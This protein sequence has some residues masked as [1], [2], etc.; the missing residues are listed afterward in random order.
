MSI[1]NVNAFQNGINNSSYLTSYTDA[2]LK[3]SL[4]NLGQ[5]IGAKGDSVSFDSFTIKELFPNFVGNFNEDKLLVQFRYSPEENAVTGRLVLLEDDGN[6]KTLSKDEASTK[7]VIKNI[8]GLLDG[9]SEELDEDN[10]KISDVQ[11]IHNVSYWHKE[12][13]IL[14]KTSNSFIYKVLGHHVG[15]AYGDYDNEYVC[16]EVGDDGKFIEG[17]RIFIANEMNFLADPSDTPPFNTLT[18]DENHHEILVLVHLRRK[19][20]NEKYQ[21]E[22]NDVDW[23]LDVYKFN[24]NTNSF[25]D[26]GDVAD[27]LTSNNIDL[28][29]KN[30]DS[31][32]V[33]KPGEFVSSLLNGVIEDDISGI[34]SYLYTLPVQYDSTE[35]VAWSVPASYFPKW[36]S[37]GDNKSFSGSGTGVMRPDVSK[38]AEKLGI[39]ADIDILT[40]QSR[41]TTNGKLEYFDDDATTLYPR[42]LEIYNDIMYKSSTNLKIKE[43]IVGQLTYNAWLQAMSVEGITDT[44]K[45]NDYVMYMPIDYTFKYTCNS[46]DKSVIYNMASSVPVMF[47]NIATVT[48]QNVTASVDSVKLLE[49]IAWDAEKESTLESYSPEQTIFANSTVQNTVMYDL[50]ISYNDDLILLSMKWFVSFVMPYIDST[51]FW[52][53]NGIKTTNYAKGIIGEQGNLIITISDKINKFD[54]SKNIL[55]G[56][57]IDELKSLSSDSFE[58][59]EFKTDYVS[60]SSSTSMRD[61][62]TMY[63]YLPSDEIVTQ[64]ANTDTFSYLKGAV[65]MSMSAMPLEK[66]AFELTYAEWKSGI[67]GKYGYVIDTYDVVKKAYD[68]DE[69]DKR[70]YDD[71]KLYYDDISYSYIYRTSVKSN[72]LNNELGSEGVVMSFWT[73]NKHESDN[74]TYYGFDYIRKPGSQSNVAL[75]FSYMTNLEQYVKH[76]AKVVFSPDDYEH[77]QLIFDPVNLILKNN[78]ID[79]KQKIWPTILNRDANYYTPIGDTSKDLGQSQDVSSQQYMNSANLVIEFNDTITKKNGTV[80]NVGNSKTDRRFKIDTYQYTSYEPYTYTGATKN[81]KGEYEI[82]QVTGKRPKNI[83]YGTI[84]ALINYTYY[85][86]EYI[87]NSKY[88]PNDNTAKYQY[89]SLDIKEVLVR[90]INAENRVN[91]IGFQPLEKEDLT[92]GGILYNAYIGT[93]YDDVDKSILHIGTSS[94]N[95]NLGTTTMI[96]DDSASKLTK[97]RGMSIDFDEIKLNGYTSV[98]GEIITDRPL[99]TARK[100]NSKYTTYV[101]TFYPN[102]KVYNFDEKSLRGNLL[103]T[104]TLQ[105]KQRWKSRYFDNPKDLKVS[106][107]NVTRLLEEANI[108]NDNNTI[109]RGDARLLSEYTSTDNESIIENAKKLASLENEHPGWFQMKMMKASEGIFESGKPWTDYYP[110][111]FNEWQEA[112]KLLELRDNVITYSS[113]GL[114]KQVNI[115]YTYLKDNEDNIIYDGN[116][117]RIEKTEPTRSKQYVT[118]FE[119]KLNEAKKYHYLELSTDLTNNENRL[120]YGKDTNEAEFD[121][122]QTNPI[123]VSYVDI[124][125]SYTATYNVPTYTYV[126]MYL[127]YDPKSYTEVWY[128]DGCDLCSGESCKNIKKCNKSSCVGYWTPSYTAN[129][130]MACNTVKSGY[131]HTRWYKDDL[132]NYVNYTTITYYPTKYYKRTD[133]ATKEDFEKLLYNK[134][135]DTILTY[136]PSPVVPGL[137][138]YRWMQN[139][140]DNAK[141]IA[142]KV[143]YPYIVTS[144]YISNYISSYLNDKKCYVEDERK[145]YTYEGEWHS[146]KKTIENAVRNNYESVEI[147]S[148]K[149]G[150]DVHYTLSRKENPIVSEFSYYTWAMNPEEYHLSLRSVNVREIMTSHSRPEFFNEMITEDLYKAISDNNDIDSEIKPSMPDMNPAP[151]VDDTVL[152]EEPK[153]DEWITGRYVDIDKN[154]IVLYDI[155][156]NTKEKQFPKY[157]DI[158]ENSKLKISAY[159][160]KAKKIYKKNGGGLWEY[161]ERQ[162]MENASELMNTYTLNKKDND[163]NDVIV[164]YRSPINNSKE[165]I[166]STN[167]DAYEYEWKV[168]TESTYSYI[169]SI[170]NDKKNKDGIS[171]AYDDNDYCGSIW[172]KF[173]GNMTISTN[174]SSGFNVNVIGKYVPKET[175][176]YYFGIFDDNHN[177]LIKEDESYIC[178]NITA[179]VD[180]SFLLHSYF[181]TVANEEY[182]SYSSYAYNV[183]R[184]GDVPV[185][186]TYDG[187]KESK[188]FLSSINTTYNN[189][190]HYNKDKNYTYNEN[191]YTVKLDSNYKDNTETLTET[192]KFIQENSKKSVEIKFIKD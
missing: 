105:T 17:F 182:S 47:D 175:T 11:S 59:K 2:Y 82:R 34:I 165:L 178:M 63:A 122:M 167:K 91:V 192:W 171:L 67:Q 93:S 140:P 78:S 180:A 112:K 188:Y 127:Y 52:V 185:E 183:T 104:K 103:G 164:A 106:Y 32:N 139:T 50:V 117:P 101:A 135:D 84:P 70:T 75:D 72:S 48:G 49:K 55:S 46:S 148:E 191:K 116:V 20:D 151:S 97:M 114:G 186:V 120:G 40:G 45:K 58:L 13:A 111:D 102:G 86:K 3:Q 131:V 113:D 144:P 4:A 76:Y 61:P 132:G 38:T 44:E 161:D 154:E 28:I 1:I 6:V 65:I 56:A 41:S 7:V 128:C 16:E 5:R 87:P 176:T 83:T 66:N 118:S 136:Y 159:D 54:P 184:Y 8:D 170:D 79:I 190:E 15:G 37:L 160:W 172:R 177:S 130:S 9:L 96:D 155:D 158:I 173:E 141:Y 153:E 30:Y 108:P 174:V 19:N 187:K 74:K 35:N 94:T 121:I 39:Y 36:K 23:A 21:K 179:K 85:P 107:L 22:F 162:T 189:S 181:L 169:V 119:G 145:I 110:K 138:E 51:G 27:N 43:Q 68:N 73:C 109:I 92:A 60:N 53:I 10:I 90:N 134:D 124:P 115:T 100:L 81:D 149:K 147:E 57:G 42:L 168:E 88:D 33:S 163:N 125:S 133:F 166:Q 89:P 18:Y 77:T 80:E 152:T 26:L 157:R 98:K 14:Y 156:K 12:S 143:P 126:P 24:N 137:S 62:Y 29:I 71:W 123:Q 69:Y 142:D 64:L 146:S 95:P 129:Y 25:F 31:S 99:W 150:E